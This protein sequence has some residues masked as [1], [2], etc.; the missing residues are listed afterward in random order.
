MCANSSG[1][2]KNVQAYFWS[3]WGLLRELSS[4]SGNAAPRSCRRRASSRSR[5]QGLY[6]LPLPQG[7]GS[8][9]SCRGGSATPAAWMQS[10]RPGSRRVRPMVSQ[11][12][13]RASRVA[14]RS[15]L[16]GLLLLGLSTPERQQLSVG[17][18]DLGNGVLELASLLDQW[19]NLL[20][21]FLWDMFDALLAVNHER[22]RPGR[23]PLSI[24]AQAGGFSSA[25]GS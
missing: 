24:G 15:F 19:A 25:F 12:V 4:H 3:W 2:A 5:Q 17:G 21:P 6:L 22:Q 10:S 11:K 9:R 18:E 7:H 20:H 1:I 16:L 23:M 8:L 14:G 13:P